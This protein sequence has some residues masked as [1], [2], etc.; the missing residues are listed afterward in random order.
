MRVGRKWSFPRRITRYTLDESKPLGNK[1][2]YT[3][4]NRLVYMCGITA[5]TRLLQ[6][7][8]LTG[9]CLMHAGCTLTPA[10]K[11]V[12][13]E[14]PNAHL[15]RGGP[16]NG[17][18]FII[19]P[20]ERARWIR[21]IPQIAKGTSADEVIRRLG[22]PDQDE[23]DFVVG[24]GPVT[25]RYLTYYLAIYRTGDVTMGLDQSVMLKFG[26]DNR[27]EYYMVIAAPIPP[28]DLGINYDLSK[29][30]DLGSAASTGPAISQPV[31]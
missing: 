1:L 23:L 8:I 10:E 18:D 9:C 26:S 19:S 28:L 22:E 4:W 29:L 15:S 2:R 30:P 14:H 27:F 17:Y 24:F 11:E 6:L 20:D 13:G 5:N 31:R 12:T 3:A 16:R 7:T 21:E 25:G